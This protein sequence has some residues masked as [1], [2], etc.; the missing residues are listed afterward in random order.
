MARSEAAMRRRAEKRGLTVDQQRDN[1]LKNAKNAKD[2]NPAEASPAAKPAAKPTPKKAVQ[3]S[4]SESD[5]SSSEPETKR[6]RLIDRKKLPKSPVEKVEQKKAPAAVVAAAQ[7]PAEDSIE[8]Q[9]AAAEAKVLELQ[10]AAAQAKVAQLQSLQQK[11][12][13]PTA[14]ADPAAGGREAAQ[15]EAPAQEEAAIQTKSEE[16]KKKR[17]KSKAAS[18]GAADVKAVEVVASTPAPEAAAAGGSVEATEEQAITKYLKAREAKGWT[19]MSREAVQAQYRTRLCKFSTD[20]GVCHQGDLCIF[21][22]QE[23]QLRSAPAKAAKEPPT[24]SKK[25]KKEAVVESEEAVFAPVPVPDHATIYLGNMS[26]NAN[27]KRIRQFFDRGLGT[28]EKHKKKKLKKGEKPYSCVL[29]VRIALAEGKP[30]GFAFVDF[31]SHETAQRAIG[32]D[33][34][35]FQGRQVGVSWAQ[36]A[37]PEAAPQKGD[38]GAPTATP[39]QSGCVTIFVKNLPYTINQK[40]IKKHFSC[41][42]GAGNQGK[43]T[44]VRMF[45]D[46]ETGKFKGIAYV[47]FEDD[48]TT[49]AAVQLNNSLLDGRPITIDYAVNLQDAVA[50]KTLE[51]IGATQ[52]V[53]E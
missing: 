14:K 11:S 52:E 8:A 17:K 37:L 46:Q 42:K 47:Q 3:E 36:E 35:A 30:K 53:E 16:P 45:D 24:S 20:G 33:G 38:V 19:T 48:K 10:L 18:D 32:L 4:D 28:A 25:R 13:G 23:S 2:R 7:D 6:K 21:A 50:A 12:T 29:N 34:T 1:D 5:S 41:L 40:E 51:W 49:A 9:L 27:E 43:V 15:E 31:D 39:H 44:S 22:H 26:F